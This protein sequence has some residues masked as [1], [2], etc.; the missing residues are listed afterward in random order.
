L[1]I[2]PKGDTAQALSV[3]QHAM[4]TEPSLP[5]P[6]RTLASLALQQGQHDSALA[7]LASQTENNSVD[8]RDSLALRAVAESINGRGAQGEAV[9]KAQKAVMLAPWEL[10]NWQSLAYVRSQSTE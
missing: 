5:S 1:N 10:R 9:K 8:V 2:I 4:F 3:A 7:I 6:K